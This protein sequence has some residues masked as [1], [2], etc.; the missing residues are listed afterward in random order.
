MPVM[1][2]SVLVLALSGLALPGAAYA[3]SPCPPGFAQLQASDTCVRISGRVRAESLVG[4][5]RVRSS[6]SFQT[7]A[8]G[9]VQ[10]DV[11]KPTEYGPLRAFI[12]VGNLKR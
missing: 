12:S 7:H 4:S 10:L 8:G 2:L 1:K 11:R 9:R 3:A 6:D 5:S